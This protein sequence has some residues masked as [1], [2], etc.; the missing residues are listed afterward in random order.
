MGLRDIESL[1]LIANLVSRRAG[2]QT[3]DSLPPRVQGISA[4]QKEL[5]IRSRKGKML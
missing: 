4:F 5:P 3:R 2:I 1:D